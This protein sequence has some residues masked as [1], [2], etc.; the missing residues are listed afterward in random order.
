MPAMP[1]EIKDTYAETWAIS[2]EGLFMYPIGKMLVPPL[3]SLG[4]TPNML[5]I[6]NI[7]VG[8]TA[9]YAMASAMW[10]WIVPLT[11]LH[12][13][14]DAMDGTMARMYG[15]G[16]KFGAKL[17]EF[18]DMCFGTSVSVS[19]CIC[20]YPNPYAM[21]AQVTFNLPSPLLPPSCPPLVV[22]ATL[23]IRHPSRDRLI[24][25]CCYARRSCFR[26][27]CWSRPSRT[28]RRRTTRSATAR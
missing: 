21:G 15:L 24:C 11:L 19:A 10:M 25:L 23:G 4:V 27:F 1:R 2:S 14:I 6:F 26:S 12:Q 22:Q 13:L 28:P 16:S 8:A 18:T 17:D 3:R 5:T 7:F 20:V 9:A